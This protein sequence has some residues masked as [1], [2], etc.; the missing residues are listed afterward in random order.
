[1]TPDE[2][3]A[4][5]AWFEDAAWSLAGHSDDLSAWF[6]TGATWAPSAAVM[7]VTGQ[8][9]GRML[10]TTATSEHRLSLALAGVADGSTLHVTVSARTVG[11]S[12]F[13][14]A[15]VGR[16]GVTRLVDASMDSGTIIQVSAGATATVV[17]RGDG[18]HRISLSAP[19]GSGGAAPAVRFHVLQAPGTISY[20]GDPT[21]GADLAEVNART[22][23]GLYLPTDA[24]GAARGAAGGPAWALIP[25]WT[26]GPL[27]PVECRFERTF[28]VEVKP[29]LNTHVSASLEVRHA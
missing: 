6:Q 2:F 17:P 26:G 14:L 15:V 20:A 12:L 25:V 29:G 18:W 1:M 3:L 8:I 22:A 4:F 9:T 21:R 13:R 7:P 23:A 10:E 28:N 24:A 5:R 16:D 19:V 27:A 11:R